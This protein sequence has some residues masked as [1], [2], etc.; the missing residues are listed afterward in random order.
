MKEA[1]SH[2]RT[3]SR[4][5]ESREQGQAKKRS[6]CPGDW[7]ESLRL[8]VLCV[9]PPLTSRHPQ[10]FPSSPLPTEG[11]WD[12]V[13]TRRALQAPLTS[14]AASVWMYSMSEEVRPSSRLPRCAELTM[15]EVMV[16]CRANGLP[17]ATTNS[18]CRTSEDRPRGRVGSGCWK[19][20]GR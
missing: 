17:M 10:P 5:A 18:P 2:S 16:F 15:P 9:Q 20:G 3:R 6:Q 1:S 14:I 11:S 12:E 4:E 8:P 13:P 7:P 19:R